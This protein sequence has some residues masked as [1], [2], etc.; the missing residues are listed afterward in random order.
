[1]PWHLPAE[2]A[3]FKKLTMGKPIVMGRNT[4]KSLPGLLP[5]RTHIVIT[6]DPNY[7]ANGAEVVHS[8]DEALRLAGDADEVMIIGGADL[9]RQTLPIA[10]RLYLTLVH[11][12]FEGDAHFPPFDPGQWSEV[13]RET[14]ERDEKNPVAFTFVTYERPGPE[15]PC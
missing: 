15:G 8:L 10:A 3:H 4:W 1:M 14:H 9:Y 11:E 7:T 12:A 5:H 6:R 13:S 2:L